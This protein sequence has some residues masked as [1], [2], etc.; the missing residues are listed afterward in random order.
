M[1]VFDLMDL[2]A[3][4]YSNRQVNVFYQND[5]FKVRVIELKAGGKIPACEM[6]SYVMFYVVKGTVLIRK[7]TEESALKEDQVLITEP[8][9]ISMESESGARLMGVQINIKER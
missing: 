3:Q 9:L 6:E 7:N 1:E 2:E 4:G 5:Q 8:A